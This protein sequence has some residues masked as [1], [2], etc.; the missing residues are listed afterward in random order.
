MK[1]AK[2]QE[3]DTI[4]D[5][6]NPV[7]PPLP[8]RVPPNRN[9]YAEPFETNTSRWVEHFYF[10]LL[11]IQTHHNYDEW[12]DID[13]KIAANC[14]ITPKLFDLH[15]ESLGRNLRLND[16]QNSVEIRGPNFCVIAKLP[17]RR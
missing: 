11:L 7:P 5:N 10:S 14:V 17:P 2:Y 9:I 13:D 16:F 4:M 3:C 1:S 6:Y 12:D 8:R 15:G